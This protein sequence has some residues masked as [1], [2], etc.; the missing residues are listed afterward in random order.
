MDTS[1]DSPQRQA[2]IPLHSTNN[3]DTEIPIPDTSALML[4]INSYLIIQAC[5]YP[6]G[7]VTMITEVTHNICYY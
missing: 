6:V 2:F 1:Q 4:I 5:I 3:I 7:I